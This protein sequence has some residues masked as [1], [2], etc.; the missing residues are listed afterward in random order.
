MGTGTDWAYIAGLFDGEGSIKV[1]PKHDGRKT[2]RTTYGVAI[3]NNNKGVLDWVKEVTGI[4]F[5]AER[6][7]SNPKWNIGYYWSL[8]ALR[9]IEYFLQNIKPFAKIKADHIAVMLSLVNTRLSSLNSDYHAPLG[10]SEFMLIA[11]LKKLNI[12]GK[13]IAFCKEG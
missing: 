1:I 10:A 8:C 12:R 7:R 2:I 13:E 3:W 9:D 6:K 11:T 5:V 4:G